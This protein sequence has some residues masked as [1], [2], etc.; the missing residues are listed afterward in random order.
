M[1]TVYLVSCV[2]QKAAG[3]RP[4]EYLGAL[5]FVYLPAQDDPSAQSM[6][7]FL[8]RQS[9]ALLSNTHSDLPLDSALTV[10]WDGTVQTSMCSDLAY[11]IHVAYNVAT[12]LAF[13]LRWIH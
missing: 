1:K 9:I 7:A 13:S 12:N 3:V 5:P 6:R 2:S 10:G 11:G 8:E 4:A